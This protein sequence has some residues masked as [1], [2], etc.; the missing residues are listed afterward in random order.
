MAKTVGNWKITDSKIAIQRIADTSTVQNLPFGTV[1]RARDYGSTAYGEGEFIYVKG[2]ASGALRDWVGIRAKAGLTTRAVASG[3]YELVGV[4]CSTLDATTKFGW[5]QISGRAVAN[6]LTQFADNGKVYLTASAGSM[7]DASVA[8]DYVIGATGR[9]GGTVT[10]G[11]LAGE[12]ELNRPTTL[13]RTAP[14]G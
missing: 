1:V 13:R 4:L 8:G 11:D 14:T 9:N 6:C 5:A 3:N 7:D 12:F 2:V 10:V